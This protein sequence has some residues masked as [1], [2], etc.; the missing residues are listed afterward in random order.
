MEL[1]WDMSLIYW[2]LLIVGGFF[3]VLQFKLMIWPGTKGE[4][5][6][7]QSFEAADCTQC[8]ST[9]GGRASIEVTVLTEAGDITTAE[10]SPCMICMNKLAVGSIVGITRFGKRLIAQPLI[11]LRQKPRLETDDA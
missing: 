11:S 8:K 6:A 1:A 3:V 7:F 10:V 4:I 5:I 2:I 9:E